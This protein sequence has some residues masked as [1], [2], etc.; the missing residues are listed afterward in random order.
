MGKGFAIDHWAQQEPEKIAV[1]TNERSI[2]YGELHEKA[3]RLAAVIQKQGL[4]PQDS[5]MIFMPDCVEYFIVFYA[6]AKLGLSIVPANALYRDVELRQLIEQNEPK[7]AFVLGEEQEKLIRSV[8]EGLPIVC[9]DLKSESFQTLLRSDE[10]VDAFLLEPTA[11]GVRISTSGST[12]KLKFVARSIESQMIPAIE[13]AK[14]LRLVADD[15]VLVPV[16]LSQQFG[17]VAMLGCFEIGCTVVIPPHF[18]AKQVF[19]LN[20]FFSSAAIT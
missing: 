14:A 2:S 5:I 10:G 17:M 1:L 16:P 7:M 11:C 13:F 15:V 6:A 4:K 12:G 8:D 3:S 9:A 20:T 19:S 18:K